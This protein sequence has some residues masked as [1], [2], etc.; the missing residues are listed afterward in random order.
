MSVIQFPDSRENLV[1]RNN[2]EYPFNELERNIDK[3][4][5]QTPDKLIK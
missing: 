4:I 1:R 2:Q 5:T 3:L